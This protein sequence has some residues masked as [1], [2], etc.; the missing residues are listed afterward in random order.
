VCGRVLDVAMTAGRAR[1]ARHSTLPG[2]TG[3]KT[4]QLLVR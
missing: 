1:L 3:S 2:E 4:P